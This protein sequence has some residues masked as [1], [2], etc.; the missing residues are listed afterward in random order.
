MSEITNSPQAT[1]TATSGQNTKQ[2]A[3]TS[4]PSTFPSP[5]AQT[6]LCL[7]IG[8]GTQDV[9][10][11][12]PAL[13]LEN[14]PKFILPSPAKMLAARI[15]NVT[16]RGAGL[17]LYGTNMGGG[18]FGALN[19]HIKAGLPVAIHPN[20]A[21]AVH[22]NP[23][24]VRALGIEIT[25]A[26]PKGFI[27]LSMADFDPAF[28]RTFL[29]AAELPYPDRVVA[30]AQDHGFFPTSSNR[31][32]RFQLWRR[33][34]H[35]QDGNACALLFDSVPAELT[36]LA[37]LQQ[38]IGGGMVAD[39]GS[40]AVLSALSM[41]EIAQRSYRQGIRIVNVGNSHILAF[42]V[43]R[44]KIVGIYEHHTGMRTVEELMHDLEEFSHGW[45]PDDVVRASGGHGCIFSGE[46]PAEA[47]AF[48]P[49]FILGPQRDFLAGKGQFIAPHGDMMLAGCFGLLHALHAQE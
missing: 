45:L 18:F 30:A 47:E 36:R 41:P 19:A 46:L 13:A 10:L 9:L 42:L 31:E 39:T 37:A 11:Y 22:D 34:L 14:C 38:S 1:H 8:S 44:E 2:G 35:E 33:F 7:D 26:C 49:L 32:G 4:V 5:T 23:E 40:A 27:A 21:P 43:W 20:A 16:A 6:T 24:R 29:A 17:Y 15:R 25:P 12:D 48:R 3:P 28:W